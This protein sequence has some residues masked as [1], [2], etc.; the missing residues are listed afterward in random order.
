[1]MM[2]YHKREHSIK[3]FAKKDFAWY[4]FEFVQRCSVL[5]FRIAF[6]LLL[7]YVSLTRRSVIEICA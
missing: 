5:V 1:M 2:M 7:N 4:E 6:R 3:Q